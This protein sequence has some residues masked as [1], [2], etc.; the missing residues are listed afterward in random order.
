[1]YVKVAV[2]QFSGS[3]SSSV[4]A[5]ETTASRDYSILVF[6]D[7]RLEIQATTAGRAGKLR[8]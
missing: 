2:S 1:M 6:R 7:Y 4:N 3:A 8:N 5:V